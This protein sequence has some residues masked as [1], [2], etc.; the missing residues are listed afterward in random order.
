MRKRNAVLSVLV[1]SVLVFALGGCSNLFNL[2]SK[3]SNTSGTT[4]ADQVVAEYQASLQNTSTA[5]ALSPARAI[6]TTLTADQIASLVSAAQNAIASAGLQNSTA[7]DKIVAAMV[8]GVATQVQN[9]ATSSTPVDLSA[10]LVVAAQSAVVSISKSGRQQDVSSGLTTESAIAQ[11]TAAMV[12]VTD[13]TIVDPKVRAAT[14]ASMVQEAVAALDTA[15][16]VTT[17]AEVTT[18]VQDIVQQ[19]A[20]TQTGDSASFQAVLAAATTSAAN[21]SKV[22]ADADKTTLA[23]DVATAA[24]QA[25]ADA[26]TNG[27]VVTNQDALVTAVATETA[28]IAPSDATAI[29][30]AISAAVTSNTN[31]T[32]STTV[33]SNLAAIITEPA[34]TVTATAQVG[35]SGTPAASVSVS[36]PGQTVTLNA[37]PSTTYSGGVSVVG[38]ARLTPGPDPVLSGGIYTVTPATSGTF[39][40]QVTV[41]NT[42]GNKTATATV[43]IVST[44]SLSTAQDYVNQGIQYLGSQNIEAA[45]AAFTQALVADSTNKTALFWKSFVDLMGIAV[46][47]EFVSVMRDR[48]GFSGYPSTLSVL[49][50]NTWFSQ[51]WYGTKTGFTVMGNPSAATSG[52]VRGDFTADTSA[53]TSYNFWT[54]ANPDAGPTSGQGTFVLD[55]A[56]VDYAEIAQNSPG[57][58]F[59]YIGNSNLVPSGTTIYQMDYRLADLTKPYLLPAIAAPSWAPK[60][61]EQ[62]SIAYYGLAILANV[63]DRNPSGLNAVIDGLVGATGPFGSGFDTI[64]TNLKSIALTDSVTVPSNLIGALTGQTPTFSVVITGAE[65]T[66]F[67]AELELDKGLLQYIDSYDFSYPLSALQYDFGDDSIIGYYMDPGVS[68]KVSGIPDYLVN[69]MASVSGPFK[70][71]ATTKLLADRG[72]TMREAARTS[73]ENAATDLNSAAT[74]I[75]TNLQNGVYDNYIPS[76]LWSGGGYASV[77]AYD[78]AMATELGNYISLIQS[79]HDSVA[80]TTGTVAFAPTGSAGPTV[81]LGAIF[82][83]PVFSLPNLFVYDSTNTYPLVYLGQFTFDS[84]GNPTAETGSYIQAD[85]STDWTH[86]NTVA[87]KGNPDLANIWPT[88]MT[89]TGSSLLSEGGVYSLD[90]ASSSNITSS[91]ETVYKWIFGQ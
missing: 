52:F 71:T 27:S 63:I 69:I 89:D 48:F 66:A 72:Q 60:L 10:A 31:L 9:S 51:T 6:A 26:Q 83:N 2:G 80:D 22:S 8:Q 7:V 73:V 70:Q 84:S 61:G 35:S 49:L 56:G 54:A 1:A 16:T 33:T 55:P 91:E 21:L 5:K 32:V 28:T 41:Q 3:G 53:S 4:L 76:S 78:T 81:Y 65:L 40:Y 46:N 74:A 79:F 87:L 30:T 64:V 90:F 57:S 58:P 15:D 37:S 18:A 17:A 68:T 62:T 45:E 12:K 11:V 88:Y 20:A 38:W 85:S 24:V 13:S 47:P 42:G 86:Y 34:P 67:A 39:V 59:T 50:S 14:K 23:T 82:N 29:A 19:V 44:I 77:S 43:T 36:G 25:I 75:Q